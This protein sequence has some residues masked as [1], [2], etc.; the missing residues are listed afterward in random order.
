MALIRDA[1]EADVDAIRDLFVRVYGEDYPFPG[2]YDTHWLKKSVFDD[3]TVFLV[4]EVEGCIVATG[5]VMLDAGDYDDLI[6]ELGRLVAESTKRARGAAAELIG[7]LLERIRDRIQFCFGEVRT[8][9]RGSQR[10][11]EKFGW[12]PVGFEPMKYQFAS[13][14]S[15][16]FYANVQPVARELRRNNPRLIPEAALLAQTALKSLD[17]PVDVIVQEEPDGYPTDETFVVERLMEKGVTPLLRIER[18]R[19][20]QRELFGHFSLS[21]GF[22]RISDSNSH[23]LVARDGTA[24]LGAVGFTHDPIDCKV[25]IFELIEFNDAVKGYLL[26]AVDKIAREE[27][28]VVYQ[29]VDVSAYSPKIQR[30]FERLGFV[31]VA[32]C[33]AMV[34]ENVER[35]DV[36][37]MAKVSTEYDTG[38]MRLLQGGARVKEIVEKGLEDRLLGMTITEN[39]RG[40]EIFDGLPD[41]DLHHLARIARLKTY[42]AGTTLIRSGDDTDRI[43]ILVDGKAEARADGEV[44]GELGAGEIF[45]EMG[46]VEKTKRSADVVLTTEARVIDILIPRLERLMQTHSRLG[47][48]VMRNLARGLS[49]KLRRRV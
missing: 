44:L 48:V 8:V 4:A 39:T 15:V 45:G 5:S 17:M 10:L 1:S 12:A 14:E 42:P 2:F 46:L 9:H 43:Y 23:Y 27:F 24:V 22:F 34:F 30:T 49:E 32:Y 13:R 40:V 18:G 6:G 41:G 21:H 47:F 38:D 36:L 16:V 28:G 31:P 7:T 29:E 11:A 37:R 20:R 33:P 26:A 19:V 3:D 25:R 35:L